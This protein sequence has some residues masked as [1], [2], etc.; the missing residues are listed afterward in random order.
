MES[1]RSAYIQVLGNLH[2]C[3]FI[4]TG[5]IRFVRPMKEKR[6]GGA[7]DPAHIN[8]FGNEKADWWAK[9]SLIYD[10]ILSPILRDLMGDIGRP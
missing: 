4:V 6:R 8:I 7:V 1:S 5:R 9:R 2:Q 3:F 10:I